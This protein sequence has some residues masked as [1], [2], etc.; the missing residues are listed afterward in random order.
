MSDQLL[1][2]Q[3]HRAVSC[4]RNDVWVLLLA[5]GIQYMALFP[6]KTE[7]AFYPH[8]S[9]SQNPSIRPSFQEAE[10]QKRFLDISVEAARVSN[11]CLK[12]IFHASKYSVWQGVDRGHGWYLDLCQSLVKNTLSSCQLDKQ[13]SNMKDD[14][15]LFLL[16]I[17]LSF[18]LFRWGFHLSMWSNCFDQN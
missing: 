9:S 3:L 12:C 2:S 16:K 13:Q 10:T 15:L 1:I 5:H 6:H 14:L 4:W 8:K 18:V 11:S 17:D 7:E